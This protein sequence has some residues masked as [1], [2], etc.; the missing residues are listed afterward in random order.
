MPVPISRRLGHLAGTA[1]FS[2]VL[3]TAGA[4]DP[5]SRE[6]LLATLR[7]ADGEVVILVAGRVD[8]P[9]LDGVL[10]L[11]RASAA[12]SVRFGVARDVAD[13]GR[14]VRRE[15]LAAIE[16]DRPPGWLVCHDWLEPWPGYATSPMADDLAE[17]YGGSIVVI[18]G[19]PNDRDRF[20]PEI[21]EDPVLGMAENPVLAGLLDGRTAP[22]RVTDPDLYRGAWQAVDGIIA[23]DAQGC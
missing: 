10:D 5:M 2:C 18:D 19:G 1:I 17:R 3:A 7:G 22:E 12:V 6:D 4:A 14:P 23:T 11:L 21:G 9:A 16:G 13:E 15:V 20:H 8:L